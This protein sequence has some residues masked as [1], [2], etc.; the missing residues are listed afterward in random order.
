LKKIEAIHADR[1]GY[2]PPF[3]QA[4]IAGVRNTRYTVVSAWQAYPGT[5]IKRR[6]TC[7]DDYRYK[8]DLRYQEG[9]AIGRKKGI[10]KGVEKGSGKRPW[11]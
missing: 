10:Q 11:K 7:A 9:R 3:I 5:G 2:R 8:K 1:N 6:Q 4:V